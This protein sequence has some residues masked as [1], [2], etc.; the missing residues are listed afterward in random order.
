MKKQQPNMLVRL[1][2]F[3]TTMRQYFSLTTN[4]LTSARQRYFSLT[5]KITIEPTYTPHH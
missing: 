3:S 4:Q 1:F 5:A 2:G